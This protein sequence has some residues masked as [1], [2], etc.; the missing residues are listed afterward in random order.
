[1]HPRFSPHNATPQLIESTGREELRKFVRKTSPFQKYIY[2]NTRKHFF[3]PQKARSSKWKRR[4]GGGGDHRARS[5][6]R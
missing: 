3:F 2:Y 5:N 6:A 1:M 4:E